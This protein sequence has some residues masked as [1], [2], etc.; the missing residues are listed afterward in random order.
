M[1]KYVANSFLATRISFINEVAR[2]CEAA[3]RRRR[4]GRR[5]D[6]P[7]P[8]DRRP[9][10]QPG[11][12]LRRQLPAEGRRRP[13][14]HRRDL[15]RR[16]AGPVGASRRSNDGAADERRP[17]AP[18]R[19]SAT[20]RAGRIARLGPDVQGRHR[21]HARI[22][23]DGRRPPARQRGRARSRPTT[24]RYRP[25]RLVAER[26]PAART[27]FGPIEA[28]RGADALAILTDWPEFRAI[29]A[30]GGPRGDGGQRRLRWPERHARQA[31][32]EAAGF[33]YLGVGRVARPPRRRRSRPMRV[34]VAGGAG[35]VGSHVCERARWRAATTVTCLDNLVDGSTAQHRPS[36]TGDPRSDS[37][38]RTSPRRPTV[39]VGLS[40]CTSR[41]RRVRSTTTGCPLE[42]MCGQLARDVAAAR[43]RPGDGRAADLRV[44]VRGLRRS[45]RPPAAGDVLGQRGP[46]GP[47]SC[48]DESKR[49]GE[50]LVMSMRRVH[51]VRA[52]IV[53]L[54]NTYGPRMRLDDGRVD[55]GAHDGG[56]GRAGRS[57]L[58]GDGSQTRSFCYVSDLVDGSCCVAGSTTTTTARSST[59]ATRRR[60]PSATW[61]S[62]IRDVIGTR[63]RDRLRH[64]R[65]GDPERRR[66]DITKIQRVTAGSRACAWKTGFG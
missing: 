58:H 53:R 27:R 46:V 7:R 59:S 2:L 30:R 19:G 22:A 15:R 66:P 20:S 54:F 11:H 65:P 9:L 31:K 60:S 55:P 28:A 23:G 37:S 52:T 36:S 40:S 6:R 51:G 48:Y 16:D 13:A 4:P 10:L 32:A 64:R 25:I 5:R 18:A 17:P 14:L 44:D 61:P 26:I 39:E 35:F 29:A 47:R 34:L 24:R 42:T 49:F 45:A 50:A 57:S 21:G 43:H 41:R 62:M 33:A 63:L 38:C 8:A 1:I 56:A 12:R 3:R